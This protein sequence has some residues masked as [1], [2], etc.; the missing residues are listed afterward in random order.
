MSTA[1]HAFRFGPD[2]TSHHFQDWS[3]W[4]EPFR[5]KPVRGLE[6]GSFEGRS[7]VWFLQNILTHPQSTL[8]AIDP[9]DYTEEKSIV[10]G[11]ATHIAEQF[12]WTQIRERFAHN[13]APWQ[14]RCHVMPF[15]SQVALPLVPRHPPIAFAYLD[16]SHTAA[17]VLMTPA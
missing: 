8:I 6:V 9:W 15:P 17:A 5:D 13:I 11:G 1:P 10:P 14:T 7:A 12:D 16:G 4:L 2:W 3:R